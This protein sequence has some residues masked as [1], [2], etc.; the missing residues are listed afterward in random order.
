MLTH[1]IEGTK[2]KMGKKKVKISK[3]EEEKSN[4]LLRQIGIYP[5]LLSFDSMPSIQEEQRNIEYEIVLEFAKLLPG[6]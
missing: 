1:I 5:R 3:K 4:I 6:N 2:E